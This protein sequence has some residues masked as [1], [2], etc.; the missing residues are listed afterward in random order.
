MVAFAEGFSYE[1][2]FVLFEGTG[3]HSHRC[4]KFHEIGIFNEGDTL[5]PSSI[6]IYSDLRQDILYTV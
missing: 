3:E 1:L 4:H 5:E 6:L 2:Q